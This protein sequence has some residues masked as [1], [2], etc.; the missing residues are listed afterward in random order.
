MSG[1]FLCEDLEKEVR[2]NGRSAYSLGVNYKSVEPFQ[3][4]FLEQCRGPFGFSRDRVQCPANTMTNLHVEFWKI[5]L[6]PL[7]LL[8]V[9][10]IKYDNR[11]IL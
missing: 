2:N 5:F 4:Q 9:G 3:W 11:K 8:L 7:F 1:A 6:N 10:I